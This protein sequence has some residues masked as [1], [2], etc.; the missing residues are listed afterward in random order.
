[1]GSFDLNMPSDK[2]GPSEII[3][4]LPVLVNTHDDSENEMD[5]GNISETELSQ[6]ELFENI[7]EL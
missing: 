1:M 3:V 4:E 7:R 2:D 6:K 5:V